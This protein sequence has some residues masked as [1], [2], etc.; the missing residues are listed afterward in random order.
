MGVL[1]DRPSCEYKHLFFVCFFLF[2][3]AFGFAGINKKSIHIVNPK[4]SF[5]TLKLLQNSLHGWVGC[6]VDACACQAD[7]AALIMVH[8]QRWSEKEVSRWWRDTSLH[9]QHER[10]TP[11]GPPAQSP[12]P[13]QRQSRE[14]K[15]FGEQGLFTACM[16]PN[17]G[18][19]L[20]SLMSWKLKFTLSF[21]CKK[22]PCLFRNVLL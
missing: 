11:N 16:D 1:V 12:G 17:L 9:L 5:H 3:F 13:S 20:G 7:V 19:F 10:L 8:Y 2:C 4:G 14:I 15:V 22:F 6:P 21:L 18:F